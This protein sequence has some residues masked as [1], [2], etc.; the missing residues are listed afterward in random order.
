MD[1]LKITSVLLLLLVFLIAGCGMTGDT[2]ARDIYL[3]K[4]FKALESLNTAELVSCYHDEF[5]FEDTVYKLKITD[6]ESFARYLNNLFAS[7]SVSFKVVSS[8]E[9][10]GMAAAEWLWKGKRKDSEEYFS[11]KGAS[12]YEIKEGLIKRESIYYDVRDAL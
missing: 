4:A 9:S 1:I 10:D 12:I 2:G 3:K 6:K 7:P 8:F 11:V 5:L